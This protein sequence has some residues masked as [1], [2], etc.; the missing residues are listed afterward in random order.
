M[1]PESLEMRLEPARRADAEAIARMSRRLIETGLRWRWHPGAIRRSLRDEDTEIV[2]A[3][4]GQRL[5]GFA[6]MKF[7][8]REHRAHLLLLAV[9][10]AWRRR[11]IARSLCD[12]LEKIARRGGIEELRL[13]VRAENDAALAFYRALGFRERGVLRGYYQGS[14]DAIRL[15]RRL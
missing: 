2:V 9:S 11:G 3:R 5:A 10:P 15:S 7:D 6:L 13:E 8:F 12:W 4:M 1:R 14:E